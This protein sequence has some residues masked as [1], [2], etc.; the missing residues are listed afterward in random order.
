MALKG[1]QER[2]TYRRLRKSSQ[3][4]ERSPEKTVSQETKKHYSITSYKDGPGQMSQRHQVRSGL[5]R[6]Y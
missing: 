6:V 2:G 3:G 4:V 1:W 5:K